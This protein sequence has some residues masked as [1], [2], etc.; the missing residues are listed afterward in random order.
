M[1]LSEEKSQVCNSVTKQKDKQ[2]HLGQMIELANERERE[3]EREMGRDK[4]KREK[5]RPL[6]R[7]LLSRNVIRLVNFLWVK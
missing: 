2:N 3:R 5:P 4:N 6:F 7:I 1:E